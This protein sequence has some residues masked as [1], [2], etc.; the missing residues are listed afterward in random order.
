ML[1]FDDISQERVNDWLLKHEFFHF[2][3]TY[4]AVEV[5]SFVW[6]ETL[7]L[8]RIVIVEPYDLVLIVM[9]DNVSSLI[10][11]TITIDGNIF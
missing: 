7:N 4:V 9:N 11:L 1:A 6:R 10:S 3:Y 2:I 8:P 5:E